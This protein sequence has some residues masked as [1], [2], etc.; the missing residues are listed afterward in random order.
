MGSSQSSQ[1]EW[2]KLVTQRKDRV[3]AGSGPQ[4]D[5]ILSNFPELMELQCRPEVREEM[6][7]FL[8]EPSVIAPQPQG[9]PLAWLPLCWKVGSDWPLLWS[10]CPSFVGAYSSHLSHHLG[11]CMILHDPR[12]QIMAEPGKRGF[13]ASLQCAFEFGNHW[14]A[15]RALHC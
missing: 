10:W 15:M 7:S 13:R 11:S 12:G 9:T 5:P 3:G 6:C 4:V 1:E 2:K 8:E 14:V